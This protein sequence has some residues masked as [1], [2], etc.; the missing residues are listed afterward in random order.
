MQVA[1]GLE[2]LGITANVVGAQMTIH[3]ALIWDEDTVI[4]VDAGFPGQLPQFREAMEAAGVPFE[5]LNKVFL[6]HQDIDHIG[7]LPDL[8]HASPQKVEVLA[9]EW[10]KPYIQGEKPL[11]KIEKAIARLNDLPQEHREGLKRVFENPPKAPVDRTVSD[12]EELP[13]CGGITV[14]HTPGHTPGHISLYHQPSKTLIAGDALAVVDGQLV[15]PV[16]QYTLDMDVAIQ[17]LKKLA[18]YD[19]EAVIC[20]HGGLY[21]ENVNRRIA[22]LADGR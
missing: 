6:T 17:S 7:C 8:L 10:E 4:L 1:K 22:E 5:K 3:P 19:I 11:I 21:R 9:S 13:F 14:I 2:M 16:P 20:Y 15:G 18:Q 12:G